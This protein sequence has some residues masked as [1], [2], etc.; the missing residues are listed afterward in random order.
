MPAWV[1][2]RV[3]SVLPLG[4]YLL[5]R[6]SLVVA[7]CSAWRRLPALSMAPS[8][9]RLASSAQ[10][11]FPVEVY[12]ARNPWYGLTGVSV[13]ALAPLPNVTG[14]WYSWA[15]TMTLLEESVAMVLAIT[16]SEPKAAAQPK[17]AAGRVRSSRASTA[18]RAVRG[19]GG[20]R[21]WQRARRSS[22]LDVR[23][24]NIGANRRDRK[25]N[26]MD[27]V[28]Y[29]EERL[30]IET[31]MP[32]RSARTPDAGALRG[33]RSGFLTGR[34]PSPVPGPLSVSDTA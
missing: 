2:S 6:K 27:R 33:R 22:A 30:T 26:N 11:R 16:P 17:L 5:R 10:S 23:D 25:G 24:T 14:A 13:T 18:G 19:F 7:S 34:F 1:R 8:Q 9:P 3:Q 15:P 20:G 12:L 21:R 32:R 31:P 29:C 4:S 28:S